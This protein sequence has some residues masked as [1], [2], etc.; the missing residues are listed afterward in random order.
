MGEH[1]AG[2]RKDKNAIIKDSQLKWIDRLNK[3]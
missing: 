3:G 1:I 2:F